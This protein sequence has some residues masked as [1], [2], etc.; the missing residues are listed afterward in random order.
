MTTLTQ[1]IQTGEFLLSEAN[2][3]RSRG[4]GVVTVSGAV[5]LPSGTVLGLVTATGK[6]VKY[7]DALG[8]GLGNAAVGVLYEGC[9]GVNGDYKRAIIERDAEV[10]GSM[11]NGGVALDANGI[12]DL[13]ALGIIVR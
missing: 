4:Q 5:A 10:V 1:G 2:G 6:Y 12:A 8:A 3:M 11:L 9:P 7:N 13:K